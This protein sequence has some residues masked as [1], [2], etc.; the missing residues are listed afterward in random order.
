MGLEDFRYDA[1][2]QVMV[3]LKCATC[4]V[5]GSGGPGTK[6]RQNPWE[7][8][9]RAAPHLLR[10]QELKT[11]LSLLSEHKLRDAEELRRRMPDP[12]TPC[13]KIE[14]LATFTGYLCCCNVNEAPCTFVTRS[15][16][17]M[18]DHMPRHGRQ[19]GEHKRSV[20]RGEGERL[21]Q[22]CLLQSY[23]IAPNRINYFVVTVQEA[24]AGPGSSSSSSAAA[25]AA[26]HEHPGQPA[27]DAAFLNRMLQDLDEVK[28]GRQREAALVGTYDRKTTERWLIH[29]ESAMHLERCL[30]VDAEISSCEPPAMD[31]LHPFVKLPEYPFLICKICQYACVSKEVETHL[32]RHHHDM[33][34]KARKQLIDLTA[35]TPDI[36]RTL[37]QLRS[38]QLPEF[39]E[40]PVPFLARPMTDGL[41]CNACAFIARQPQS[42]RKH[43]QTVHGWVNDRKRIDNFKKGPREDWPVPWTNNIHCQRFFPTRVACGWVEVR[44][45]STESLETEQQVQLDDWMEQ[46]HERQEQRFNMGPESRLKWSEQ[47]E[48][49]PD[50]VWDL[51][52]VAIHHMKDRASIAGNEARYN[53]LG[54]ASFRDELRK[55]LEE[56]CRTG[57]ESIGDGH[58]I[59]ETD[60]DVGSLASGNCF[61]ARSRS[62]GDRRRVAPSSTGTG[63]VEEDWCKPSVDE[64]NPGL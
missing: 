37:D 16:A 54:S 18:E 25:V 45:P 39:L 34:K 51:V 46:L 17:R 8:H 60:I 63:G 31:P 47:E 33:E 24:N 58:T 41:R 56:W 38:F 50:D 49:Q 29:T 14:G 7:N 4:L 43:C 28:R 48:S 10:K 15:L 62:R 27:A 12:R 53:K 19:P 5:P 23:S 22:A 3:C 9:L 11:M 35:T 44:Q 57:E 32:R 26:A 21:W 64:T 2:H 40:Q 6:T 20:L 42:I 13:R 36:I 61:A 30:E 55:W 1:E 52:D 59:G